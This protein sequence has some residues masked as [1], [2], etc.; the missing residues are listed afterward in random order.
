MTQNSRG[1]KH[2]TTQPTVNNKNKISRFM[3][4]NVNNGNIIILY[5]FEKSN[6]KSSII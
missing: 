2:I 4:T 5:S 3:N 6:K 1:N